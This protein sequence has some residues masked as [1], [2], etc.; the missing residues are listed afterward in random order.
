MRSIRL[1]SEI[2]GLHSLLVSSI[3][4]VTFHS[5][6]TRSGH[7]ESF[8]DVPRLGTIQGLIL[9]MKARE[10]TPRRGYYYRSW[11]GIQ[12]M[13]SMAK[14][15][16]LHHH[17]KCHAENNPC[18]SEAFDCAL[19]TRI[20]HTL[21]QLETMVGGPQGRYD[22]ATDMDT[23]DLQVPQGIPGVDYSELKI[24]QDQTYFVRLIFNIRQTI[25]G[26]IRVKTTGGY[27]ATDKNFIKL[28]QEY[29]RLGEELPAHLRVKYLENSSTPSI[30]F[31][32]AANLQCYQL[33]GI[34]MH[35]RPQLESKTQ[36]FDDG[37]WKET[38]ITC[39]S[40]A[41]KICRIHEAI[42]QNFGLN[43]LL[44]M[45]RGI[46]TAIYTILSCTM[47]H[48]VALTSPDPE[49]NDGARDYFTRHMRV[50]EQCSNS[51][52]VPQMQ[53][54]IDSL[55]QAFSA[56]LDKPF[57]LKA[58][59]PFGSPRQPHDSTTPPT[60]SAFFTADSMGQQ[61]TVNRANWGSA[62]ETQSMTPPQTATSLGSHQDVI[63][64]TSFSGPEQQYAPNA[65]IGWDP[66]GVFDKWHTA[67]H[68]STME[69]PSPGM[70]GASLHAGTVAPTSAPMYSNAYAGYFN[71]QNTIAATQT[72]I[73]P[74]FPAQIAAQQPNYLQ[75]GPPATPANYSASMH[76]Y[77]S[78][79]MWQD[80][81]A[82]TYGSKRRWDG[83][84]GEQSFKRMR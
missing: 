20:W 73:S 65:S 63:T 50:L 48:L 10:S 22:Y 67:F 78:P 27:F 11:M 55:R 7:E 26:F 82:Q 21:F 23:I 33:L 42:L 17:N 6:T 36:N 75:Q 57:E 29:R 15:L 68:P 83:E 37:S 81:V 4:D 45:V 70:S 1:M 49:L 66:S 32:Y 64:S 58:N 54:Q 76:N 59:F 24:S 39:Y 8:K 62:Y 79:G 41:T 77:V 35:H 34:I 53:V 25:T 71:G 46:N 52:P 31:H 74:N 19:K 80:A 40:A 61:D 3:F 84:A 28:N 2:D 60:D 9:I 30:P 72:G 18:G 16:S 13:I 43:G 69:T 44:C 5:L 51:W 56:D 38:M 12:Y 47:L 14:D